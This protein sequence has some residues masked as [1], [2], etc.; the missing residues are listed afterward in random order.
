M[1]QYR[2]DIS[3]QL[4]FTICYVSFLIIINVNVFLMCVK[5]RLS[6][7]IMLVLLCD[8]S[9]ALKTFSFFSRICLNTYIHLDGKRI[10]AC[11]LLILS[12]TRKFECHHR[13]DQL[14]LQVSDSS[15]SRLFYVKSS[16]SNQIVA[17]HWWMNYQII[18]SSFWWEGTFLHWVGKEDMMASM[19]KRH[20]K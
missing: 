16:I 12:S 11:F 4:G 5:S 9:N 8:I 1:W 19:W 20:A 15:L 17:I 14:K 13:G 6:E 7:Y 3:I 2:H 10:S 18:R